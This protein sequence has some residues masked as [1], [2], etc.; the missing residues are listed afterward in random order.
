MAAILVNDLLGLTP[1]RLKL[2]KRYAEFD[3]LTLAALAAYRQEVEAGAFPAAE[4]TFDMPP[5]ELAR[6][7]AW[8]AS[9]DHTE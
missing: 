2:A 7:E 5:E 8:L 3:A 1:F 4:H 6:V 9:V